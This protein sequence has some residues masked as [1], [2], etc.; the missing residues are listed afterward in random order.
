[1]AVVTV[2]WLREEGVAHVAID[3]P[4]R[5][6]AIGFEVVDTLITA[7][8]EAE[9][10]P[11]VGA[12]VLTGAGRAFSAGG[13]LRDIADTIRS[14]NPT[15][16]LETMRRFHSLLLR[17]VN[18]RLPIVTAVNGLAF[19][20]AFNLILAT[21]FVV[22]AEEARFCQVF[23]RIGVIPDMGGFYFLP[24][25]VGLQRAKELMFFARELTAREALTLGLV[26]KIEPDA[27]STER[28][29]LDVAR[30]LAAGPREAISLIKRL[31]NRSQDLG[32]EQALELE[33]LA[34]A[35][36]MGT[37]DCREG[38]SAFL[39]KRPARFGNAAT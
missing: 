5:L 7:L 15:A 29:A 24:R 28:T 10:D 4:E 9:L 2:N 21:D 18:S 3:R 23:T 12:V 25:R 26:N 14:D 8:S 6:N 33:A 34:Q 31:V 19:G 27:V 20:A 1:M 22:A 13:D 36:I 11:A 30:K 16:R 37:P 39:E 38:L 17:M 35:H 32:F